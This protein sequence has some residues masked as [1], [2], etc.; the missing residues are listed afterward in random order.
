M[1]VSVPILLIP[2][3]N[4]SARLFDPQLEALWRYAPVVLCDSHRQ[5]SVRTIAEQILAYAPPKFAVC[6]LSLGGFVAQELVRLAPDRIDRMALLATSARPSGE[7]EDKAREARLE[8]ARTPGRYVEIPPLHYARNVHP[9][10]QTDDILRAKH[11]A[12]TVEVGMQGYFNQQKAI[13]TRPDG[14]ASLASIHCPT[15]VVVGDEDMI[16]PP[17]LAREMAGAIPG[18]RLVVIP[19]CGHLCTLERPDAVNAVL[20]TWCEQ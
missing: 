8:I 4:C 12:M 7:A 18:S 20:Q 16:T 11:R 17:E 9:S 14:R 1:S 3:L 6:G 5:D 2:G 19:E 15:V 10:R 13:G